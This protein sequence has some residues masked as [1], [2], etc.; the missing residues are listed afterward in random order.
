MMPYIIGFVVGA[1]V[2]FL[3]IGLILYIRMEVK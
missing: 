2:T 1:G 3:V